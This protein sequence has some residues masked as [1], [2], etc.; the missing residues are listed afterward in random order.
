MGETIGEKRRGEITKRIMNQVLAGD[1][2]PQIGG[3]MTVSQLLT[4]GEMLGMHGIDLDMSAEEA[5]P[6]LESIGNCSYHAKGIC[7]KNGCRGL[8]Q[9]R[10]DLEANQDPGSGVGVMPRSQA[11]AFV[12]RCRQI[13]CG[14]SPEKFE[15]LIVQFPE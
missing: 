4:D 2:D 11:V 9:L 14:T 13:G 5:E 8:D 15:R 10:G 1:M 7:L 6:I 3:A 12:E